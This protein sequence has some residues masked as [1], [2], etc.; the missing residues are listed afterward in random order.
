MSY[1]P[2]DPDR[3]LSTISYKAI[4]LGVPMVTH[5][6]QQFG[7]VEHVL[8]VPELDVFDGIVVYTGSGLAAM[9]PR[10]ER[11]ARAEML[12]VGQARGLIRFVDADQVEAI[13]PAYVKCTFDMDKVS[14]LPLPSGPP[15]LH[16]DMEREDRVSSAW[17][18]R[19]GPWFGQWFGRARWTSK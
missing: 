5:S 19:Y 1:D 8:Q 12:R 3:E 13:T 4:G 18:P 11:L 14:D 17:H 7:V 6:G 2:A 10:N 9:H 15:V 16:P